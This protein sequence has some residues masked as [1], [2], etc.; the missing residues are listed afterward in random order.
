M[1][2][3]ASRELSEECFNKYVERYK[4]QFISKDE[5]SPTIRAANEILFGGGMLDHILTKNEID[6]LLS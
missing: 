3:E 4:K 1:R 5:Y 2:F 6:F